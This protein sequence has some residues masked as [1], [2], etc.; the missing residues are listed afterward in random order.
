MAELQVPQVHL[1]GRDALQ[2]LAQ[3]PGEAGEG[4]QSRVGKIYE[5]GDVFVAA[6][7]L[8]QALAEDH[9]LVTCLAVLGALH[10]GVIHVLLDALVMGLFPGFF[11]LFDGIVEGLELAVEAVGG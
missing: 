11:P 10:V 5:L 7:E 8:A 9:Q 1:L 2:P 3:Q 4:F 6:D